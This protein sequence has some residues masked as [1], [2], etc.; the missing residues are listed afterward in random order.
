MWPPAL[1]AGAA[2]ASEAVIG[3]VTPCSSSCD[4]SGACMPLRF[5]WGA[6]STTMGAT[7]Q[8]LLSVPA[9]A[10]GGTEAARS[11]VGL[12]PQL[13]VN[14]TAIRRGYTAHFQRAECES[15]CFVHEL[16]EETL[17]V[18]SASMWLNLMSQSEAVRRSG[19]TSVCCTCSPRAPHPMLPVRTGTSGTCT[20]CCTATPSR[21]SLPVPRGP[22]GRWT[23]GLG[24]GRCRQNGCPRPE[25]LA[26]VGGQHIDENAGPLFGGLRHHVL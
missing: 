8:T 11:L 14:W 6:Q 2:L 22:N 7:S 23:A 5:V 16:P 9:D 10:C 18:Q 24:F 13:S 4:R 19:W 3:T 1:L 17:F 15:L 20:I 21:C 25:A 26:F 12:Q